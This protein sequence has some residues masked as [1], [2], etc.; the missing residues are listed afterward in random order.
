MESD[1][2]PS[3]PKPA[4]GTT[5]IWLVPEG[6][7]LAV[8]APAEVRAV[9]GSSV[10]PPVEVPIDH[11]A[12]PGVGVVR[13][14]VGPAAAA[15]GVAA[16]LGRR[17]FRAVVSVGIG[18]ALPGHSTL[19]AGSAPIGTVV[20]ADRSVL[21]DQGLAEPGRFVPTAAM[22]FGAFSDQSDSIEI[23]AALRAALEPAVDRVGPIATVSTC[24]GTD[25]L[26]AAVA[27]RTSALV[28]AMEG[29]AVGLAAQRA[30]L[31]FAELRVVSNTTGDRA[32]QVWD[33]D[34]ALGVLAQVF[35]P[36]QT[37]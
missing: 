31:P 20:L 2:R 32:A 7:L 1:D 10:V 15:A 17:R 24:S 8:A 34:A 14:G 22:G 27:G 33:L 21:A 25:E 5:P 6:T 18:G 30:G 26:A 35:G 28:E 23:D 37:A 29:A 19:P 9:L 36:A 11:P 13:T 4:A 12:R 16:T 3:S